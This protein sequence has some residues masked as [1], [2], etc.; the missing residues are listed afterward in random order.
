[1]HPTAA[2]DLLVILEAGDAPADP[3]KSLDA[4]DEDEDELEADPA[5]TKVRTNPPHTATGPVSEAM[6]LRCMWVPCLASHHV[7]LLLNLV[8]QL[9]AAMEASKQ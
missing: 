6:L 8:L 5:G 7:H 4:G 9:A 1:M 3:S 2:G